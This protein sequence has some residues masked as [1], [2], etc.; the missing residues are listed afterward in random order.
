MKTRKNNRK[1]FSLIELLIVVT[2][3]LIIAAIAIPN[4][5][6]SKI[7]ANETAAV[8]PAQRHVTPEALAAARTGP[9]TSATGCQG[10]REN[11]PK[12]THPN[13]SVHFFA[14]DSFGNSPLERCPSGLRNTTGNRV[15]MMSVPRV[16]S[17]LS[18][19][20]RRWSTRP[21]SARVS[22][23]EPV[24]EETAGRSAQVVS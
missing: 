23:N 11:P 8:G 12:L 9:G 10:R 14:R 24:F 4:L 22:G 16:R 20:N 1:G 17:S 7:Q 5:M 3:I 21:H 6:R 13:D 15:Y 18:V 2:I 19:S